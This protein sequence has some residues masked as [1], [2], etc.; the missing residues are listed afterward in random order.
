MKNLY[1]TLFISFISINVCAQTV[2]K[3]TSPSVLGKYTGYSESYS[4]GI[5]SGRDIMVPGINHTFT[6]L[7]NSLV[8]L[9]Q[10]SDEG[11]KVNYKGKY[12]LVQTSNG[13]K[14][15]KC[16][17]TEITKSQYPSTP[18]Y[19]ITINSDG[20]IECTENPGAKTRIPTFNL[21]KQ[22]V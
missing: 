8:N 5:I 2:S 14:L 15:L 12:T 16:K 17:M 1:F 13:N 18:E 3:S 9:T 19:L 20:T 4:M 11:D 6:V 10:V 21:K 7:A 22:G